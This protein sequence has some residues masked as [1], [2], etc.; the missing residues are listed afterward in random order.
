MGIKRY[1]PTRVPAPV[2]KYS[3]ITKVPKDKDWYVFSGQVGVDEN[4]HY[5]TDFNEQVKQAISN[6]QGLLESEDMDESNVVKVNLWSCKPIDWDYFYAAWET[7]F[8]NDY[9]SMTVGYVDA[10]G[11]PEIFLEIEIWAA[12]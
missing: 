10:L 4:G 3:H 11:V 6:I 2:G 12:K 1:S 5:S 9:P 7:F 8:P